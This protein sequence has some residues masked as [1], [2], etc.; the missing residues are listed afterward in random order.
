MKTNEYMAIKDIVRKQF[1]FCKKMREYD[2]KCR[3]ISIE[4]KIAVLIGWS[5][6]I[7]CFALL[8]AQ[9]ISIEFKRGMIFLVFMAVVV[10]ITNYCSEKKYPRCPTSD[11]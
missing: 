4:R 2:E 9:E 1:Q 11:C 10:W 6:I 7:I 3:W 8:L 5:A